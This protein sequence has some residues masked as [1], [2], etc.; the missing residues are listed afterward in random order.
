VFGIV[1]QAGGHIDVSSSLGEGSTFSVYLPC[2]AGAAMPDAAP[3]RRLGTARTSGTIL[4]VE[5]QP[6]VRQLTCKMLRGMGYKVLEA[7]DGMQALETV[8]THGRPIS[9]LLTDVIMPGMNGREVAAHL[10]PLQPNME[11]IFMSGYTDRIIGDVID[12]TVKF[13]QKPF[14]TE[15][16]QMMV[17]QAL[18]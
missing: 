10:K 9:L 14:T 5:D 7:G 11:V 8:R 2:M 12:S 3:E 1:S 15:Q 18:G 6:Q 13:L 17:R 16:L 4:V